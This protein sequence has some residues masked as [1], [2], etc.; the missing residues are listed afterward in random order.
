M[1]E[2]ILLIYYGVV[3]C[4]EGLSQ[5][6]IVGNV[7]DVYIQTRHGSPLSIV[8]ARPERREFPGWLITYSPVSPLAQP[9]SE[10]FRFVLSVTMS[11]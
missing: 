9:V 5:R 3:V 11:V 8:A 1:M 10:C 4:K 7:E 6:F 2:L